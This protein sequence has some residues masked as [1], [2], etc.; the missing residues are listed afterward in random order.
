[1][2][3]A[4]RPPTRTKKNVQKLDGSSEADLLDQL[5]R[6]FHP[7]PSTTF[8]KFGAQKCSRLF[9]Y[10]G[11]FWSHK[12]S[13]FDISLIASTCRAAENLRLRPANLVFDPYSLWNDLK[14]L[15]P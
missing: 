1:M 12:F 11:S 9:S 3:K 10:Q 13:H 6:K 7:K 5:K 8:G 4:N 2:S 14:T 15:P